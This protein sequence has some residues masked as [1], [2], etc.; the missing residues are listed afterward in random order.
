[1]RLISG[2]VLASLSI[3][4]MAKDIAVDTLSDAFKY[5]TLKG[6]IRYGMQNR[7]SNYHILQD[8]PTDTSEND[9]QAYSAIGGYIGYETAPLYN[10]SIGTTIYTSNPIGSNPSD[11]M[12]LGGL[13]EADGEQ[14]SY[15][16]VGEAFVKFRKD[17]QLFKIGRQE[18]ADY[19]FVSL[20]NV[21]MTPFTHQG[22]IYENSIFDGLNINLAYL[23]SQKARNATEFKDMVRSARVST[24]CGEV[25]SLGECV[26]D[27][28]K[29]TIRGNYNPNDYDSS[30]NYVGEDKDMPL[31]GIKY[32]KDNY[33]IEAWDYYVNDFVNTLYLLGEY[34][35][36]PS[37]DWD[38][39]LLAQYS[40]QQDV[41]GGVAG[42]IDTGF[43]GF[44]VS[45]DYLDGKINIFSA[46]NKVD[47][48]EE[49]YDGGSIFVRW[50]TPQLFNSTQVQDGNLAGTESFGAGVQFDLGA[51][52]ILDNTVIRFRHAIFDMPDELYMIDARQDRTESTFDLRYSFTKKSG[53]GIFTQ[54]DGLSIQFRVAYNDFKTDY[55]LEE[56]MKIHNYNAFSVTDDFLDARLTVDYIFF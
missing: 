38:I 54:L 56:Y 16:V 15:S 44:K 50:G 52:D 49:S 20:S 30:G 33:K 43:Y 47:Y 4:L 17:K 28:S 35:I 41:G 12:G 46:Y 37:K 6:Q 14:E 48:N 32:N 29:K 21:R 36:K 51:L 26:E 11:E 53:F 25:N 2:V 5:G 10:I 13:Y 39:S 22:A 55:D 42:N 3:S 8:A 18:L 23:T 7:D 19:R 24:G 45:A 1:M 31:I 9:I 34:K 27:G 40:N